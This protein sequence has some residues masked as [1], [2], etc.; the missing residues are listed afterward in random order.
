MTEIGTGAPAGRRL[1]R[2]TMAAYGFG[3]AAY[4]VKDA[5]FGTFLLLF[6]NQVLGVPAATVGL[7]IMAA[8]LFDA[9]IDPLVGFLSDRTRSRWG[10]RHPWM[11][12][13]ALPIALG[14]IALWDPPAMGQAATLGWLFG[15]AVVV[16]TAISCYEVPSVA[17]TPELS[18][19][20]DER[21]RIM[22][23]RYLFG[24]VG[25]LSM[26]VTAYL[27]VLA[28]VPAA[29][30]RDAYALFGIVSAAVIVV[31]ILASAAGTHR[32][33]P[34]LPQPAIA[35][36]RLSDSFRELF[37]T[38]RNRA[39]A[40]LMIAGLCSYTIQGLGYALSNYF[41]AY[42]WRL[43]GA[44]LV[45]L[46]FALLL[47]AFGAFT[48]APRV[49]RRGSKARW[50]MVFGLSAAT[51]NTGPYWLRL[52]GLF[53]E[54]GTTAMFQV[55]F[56]FVVLGTMCSVAGFILGASMMADV[57]E[58]SEDV[59]G[60]RSEGVFFAGSLFVQK[61]TSGLGIFL[62]GIMLTLAGFPAGARP[63]AVD[64]ATIDRLTLIFAGSYVV[65][66]LAAVYA[67]SRFPFGR[68]EHESR[69]A[70]LAARR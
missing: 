8:L 18:G 15:W 29:A 20:Y 45:Y 3:A 57:V 41:Y 55:Y 11:Y 19:D 67:F 70:R 25:G 21:T 26:L 43:E 42:V 52:A 30:S 24:W 36:T 65:I 60:R 12:A 62:A 32:E 59:T 44:A 54:P 16:R 4:G 53:P 14:Y 5:G 9:F 35:P 40:V 63:G 47:G 10:R 49:A 13:S 46:I 48:V 68:A 2:G 38:I 6:Y 66:A 7:V 56:A 50:A 28:P 31:A 64:I 34:N 33:I 23:W 61:C 17:L 39:F 69:L 37:E 27:V 51:L 58:Q 1:R 22:A